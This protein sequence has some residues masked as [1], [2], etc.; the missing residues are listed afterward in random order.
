MCDIKAIGLSFSKLKDHGNL[1]K[2]ILK[3]NIIPRRYVTL[4]FFMSM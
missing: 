1:K 2:Y 4:M 3:N